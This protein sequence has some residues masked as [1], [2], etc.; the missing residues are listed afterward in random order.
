MSVRSAQ[1]MHTA[2][3]AC[4]NALCILKPT[5]HNTRGRAQ[6]NGTSCPQS[7]AN[8]AR[9]CEL[10]CHACTLRLEQACKQRNACAVTH[11]N[12][13]SQPSRILIDTTKPA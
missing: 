10:S 2:T 5:A 9:M 1:R 13:K 8:Q 3:F 6:I 12:E 7:F 11:P 4:A